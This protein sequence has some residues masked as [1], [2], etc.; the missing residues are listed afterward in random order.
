MA[1]N[2]VT[3]NRAPV[4]TLW[5]AIVNERMGFEPDEAFSLA[6]AVTGLNAQ[7]KGQRLGIY[8]T[9]EERGEKARQ[10]KPEEAFSVKV[11][12]RPVPAINTDKGVRGLREDRAAMESLADS[13]D[14]DE[15]AKK[16]YD[17]YEKFRPDIPSGKKGWGAEGKL[18][19]NY[20]R[21]LAKET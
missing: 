20:I 4:M 12:G 7:S 8:E 18:D 9:P 2:T 6:R 3:V 21:S 1:E 10:R 15:L 17:L 5:A 13:Y 14:P 11:L 19:L 16:A